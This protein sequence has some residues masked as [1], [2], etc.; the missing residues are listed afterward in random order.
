MVVPDG[1]FI[2]PRREARN[3]SKLFAV[4]LNRPS[5]MSSGPNGKRPTARVGSATSISN[6]TL[7]R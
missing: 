1:A 5:A 7:I 3:D 6:K 4:E 2:V